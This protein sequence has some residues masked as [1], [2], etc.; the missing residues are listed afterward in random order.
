[1]RF[2]CRA[3]NEGGDFCDTCMGWQE[4][5][6]DDWMNQGYCGD[7]IGTFRTNYGTSTFCGQ[8]PTCC[9]NPAG[10]G[11]GDNAWHF[12]DGVD[13]RFVGPCLGCAGNTDCTFWNGVDNGTY[14]RISVCE[15]VITP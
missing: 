4:V 7:V 2:S 9:D 5:T 14:T 8:A 1:M 11:G 10:C 13:N 3:G 12:F 15:R 6:Y